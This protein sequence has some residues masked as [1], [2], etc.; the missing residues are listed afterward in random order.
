MS[1]SLSGDD[2]YSK[3]AS[4]LDAPADAPKTSSIL[5]LDPARR[6]HPF[7]SNLVRVLK[8]F[9]PGVAALL[10]VLVIAWPYLKKQ[11]QKFSISFSSIE[12]VENEKPAMINPRYTGFD[13]NR[14]PFSVTADIARNLIMDSSRVDLE[15]PKADITMRDGSWLLITAQEGIY[16]R[17]A[18]I[19]D[20]NG[21]VNLFHDK[22][23]EIV[24]QSV[25][26]DL[27]SATAEGTAPVNG[28]GPIGDLK[29]EGF[30][31]DNK[32]NI[33]HFTGK[34]SLHLYPDVMG[35]QE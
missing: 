9:F 22:G 26:I 4:P 33:I 27:N 25:H 28:H 31:M 29:S 2:A 12:A 3:A 23:Y 32:K 30:R 13:S 8:V 20:L 34:A 16:G 17:D 24:T 19:L 35:Q 14:M 18:Q 21:N 11:T 1:D 6:L 7:Y 5:K 15:M 10:I